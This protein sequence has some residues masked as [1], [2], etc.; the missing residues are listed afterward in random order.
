[1]NLH[2]TSHKKCIALVTTDSNRA[3]SLPFSPV[4]SDH[5][6]QHVTPPPLCL[7]FV[8]CFWLNTRWIYLHKS[9]N[10]VVL[11]Q[12]LSLMVYGMRCRLLNLSSFLAK[13]KKEKP[14]KFNDIP[15]FLF[16]FLP[17][18][19]YKRNRP[20]VY[21]LEFRNPFIKNISKRGMILNAVAQN[22]C[23][24]VF[25]EKFSDTF[26]IFLSGWVN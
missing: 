24:C 3:M 13:H 6:I 9:A 8:C 11:P 19:K 2:S 23:F 15:Q 22:E 16:H 4:R 1:M 10:Q 21:L 26:V 7:L 17:T 18:D 14:W 12:L 5:E 25:I 20:I